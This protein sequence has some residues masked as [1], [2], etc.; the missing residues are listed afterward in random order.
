MMG[1]SAG[2]VTQRKNMEK[3]PAIF[4]K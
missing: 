4:G 1:G 3:G 2:C